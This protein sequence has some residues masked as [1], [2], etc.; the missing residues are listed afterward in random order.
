MGLSCLDFGS[1][2]LRFLTSILAKSYFLC[3]LQRHLTNSEIASLPGLIGEAT[4]NVVSTDE[5]WLYV[6]AARYEC[7]WIVLVFGQLYN[8][9]IQLVS[10]SF[11]SLENNWDVARPQLLTIDSGKD[12]LGDLNLEAYIMY[13]VW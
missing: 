9:T 3:K 10:I 11:K 13:N 6:F 4:S 7:M 1:N 5:R 12:F 2:N 8:P